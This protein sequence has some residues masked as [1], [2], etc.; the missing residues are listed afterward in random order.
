M[1]VALL[2]T[3]LAHADDLDIALTMT[4]QPGVAMTFPDVTPGALPSITL[5]LAAPTAS[6]GGKSV[7]SAPAMRLDIDAMPLPMPAECSACKPQVRLTIHL[8][9]A[10]NGREKVI[11]A[12]VITAVVGEEAEV[13]QGSR[14][15]V[16][17]ADGTPG[18]E[19]HTL[20][21]RMIYTASA[22]PA[23]P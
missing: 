3:T 12:P 8:V 11:S 22:A 21:L 15:P 23:T 10:D 1:L 19:E 9:E 4:G 6:P 2:A 7:R 16:T 20:S 17:N 14:I 13:K 18:F 5:P